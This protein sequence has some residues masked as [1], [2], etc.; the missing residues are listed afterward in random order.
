[1]YV[2]VPLQETWA[3]WIMAERKQV[4]HASVSFS[5]AESKCRDVA[6]PPLLV[7]QGEK[8]WH[9]P[10]GYRKGEGECKNGAHQCLHP[11]RDSQQ[12]SALSVDAWRLTD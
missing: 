1:M 6:R 10:T 3:L 8:R 4:W 11:W 12:V 2:K 7:R 5:K 9:V